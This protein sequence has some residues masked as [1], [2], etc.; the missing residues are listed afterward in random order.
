M[1]LLLPT[2]LTAALLV[3]PPLAAQL[4]LPQVRLPDPVDVTGEVGD[5]V[6]D[7]LERTDAELR[8]EAQRLLDL[9]ARATRRLL[10]DHPDSIEADARGDLA[11]RGELLLQGA[12]EAD[13][14]ALRRASFVVLSTEQIK[15]LD[16]AVVRLGIPAG[17]P[18]AKAENLARGLAPGADVT[19]DH[20]HFQSG[21]AGLSPA[22]TGTPLLVMMQAATIAAEVGVI[23]SAP[24]AAI[25][26]T[27]TR[28]FA[29]G[30]P[31]P[32]NH[33]SAVASLLRSAGVARVRVAD[34]Y[35]ADPAGGNALAI[36]RALGWLVASGTRV[37]TIS[38]VG[39]KNAVIGNAVTAAQRKGVT[40][41]AAVG[42]DGPAAPPA[43]P[44]SYPG[45]VAITG[46]DARGRALIEAGRALNLDYAAPG[47][48]VYA[49]DARGKRVRW[50]GTSFA[51]PLAAA[52][53][54][55][56]LSGGGN[57]RTRLDAEAQ[58]L[59]NK[60]PDATYGRGLLCGSCARKK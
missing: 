25:A 26:T 30:A 55:A 47:A 2:I 53:L 3:A 32:A 49:L 50:R 56:A 13:L 4:A 16:L 35:G 37:V 29:K 51:A 33:G 17:L 24:S 59:G 22:A 57:W 52:R 5:R 12:T 46:V 60:G 58:D 36:A 21:T 31:K 11:R 28:G 41:V 8:R 10:R 34:V 15:G 42:N 23:D 48:D 44:A 20:L 39:P 38:L 7:I 18:L 19:A 9:R 43:Y 27:A 40:V 1:R 6:G 45:V 14:A 54:A